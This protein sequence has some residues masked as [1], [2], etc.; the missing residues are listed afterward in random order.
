M[1]SQ[2]IF[3]RYWDSYG[4]FSALFTS[5]YLYIS[6]VLTFITFPYWAENTWWD[7]VFQILPNVLGFSLG[8][9]AIWMAIGDENFRSLISGASKSGKPSPFMGL[10]AAFVHFIFIQLLAILVALVANAYYFIPKPEHFFYNYTQEYPSVFYALK[11][12]GNFVGYFLFI[13]ALM[14]ALAATFSILRISSWYEMHQTAL[15]KT[16]KSQA[17]NENSYD[18]K[19]KMESDSDTK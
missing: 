4:G 8:G 13:Y 5:A 18:V 6:L 15:K 12:I 1:K 3:R 11:L 14:L 7:Q 17:A 19:K 10:S 9:Y 2:N 16:E